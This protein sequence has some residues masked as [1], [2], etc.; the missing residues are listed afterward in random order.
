MRYYSMKS[1]IEDI[2]FEIEVLKS[3]LT[4]LKVDF[5][6]LKDEEDPWLN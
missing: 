3:V 2:K 1:S 6:V 5:N 4:W